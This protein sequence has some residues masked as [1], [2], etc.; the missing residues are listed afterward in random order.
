MDPKEV[1]MESFDWIHLALDA[2]QWLTVVNTVTMFVFRKILGTFFY[3]A[4]QPSA[5]Q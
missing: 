5:S 2:N 4:E 1:G 3:F